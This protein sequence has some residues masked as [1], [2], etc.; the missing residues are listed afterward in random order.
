MFRNFLENLISN[1]DSTIADF[2][3]YYN[4][5]KLDFLKE[6][7]TFF[8][9]MSNGQENIDIIITIVTYINTFS[10]FIREEDLPLTYIY[11]ASGYAEKERE[12]K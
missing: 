2:I 3:M 1:K 4:K 6:V 11:F 7:Y 8:G 9:F 12:E 10:Y 5:Y